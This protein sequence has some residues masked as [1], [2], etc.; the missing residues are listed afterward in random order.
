MTKS[1]MLS[2]K[3]KYILLILNKTKRKLIEKT[4]PKCELPITVYIYC[5]K[6]NK[7]CLIKNNINS[8]YRLDAC[9][10][11]E[12]ENNLNG[13]VVAR[14]TLKCIEKHN[15]ELIDGYDWHIDDLEIFD[16]PKELSEFKIYCDKLSSIWAGKCDRCRRLHIDYEG[17]LNRCDRRLTKAP[18][19][20]CYVEE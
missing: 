15:S 4:N 12:F 2:L 17:Y 7:H 14:F 19:N 5:T 1:I 3:S 8:T 20:Y 9:Y 6:D 16:R 10:W 18:Q 13:K 11:N